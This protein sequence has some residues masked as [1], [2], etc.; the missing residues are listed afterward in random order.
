MSSSYSSAR[1]KGKEERKEGN[2]ELMFICASIVP[3][4]GINT[5]II[6]YELILG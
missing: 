4:I 6:L 1:K 3:L 5:L 2:A